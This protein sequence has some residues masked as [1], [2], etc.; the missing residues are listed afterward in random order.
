M[1]TLILAAILLIPSVAHSDDWSS[2]DTHRELGYL[3]LHITDLAQT[4]YAA[5]HPELQ[6]ET[7]PLLGKHP[8]V[9]Q[10]D[11]YMLLTGIVHTGIS[12]LLPSEYRKAFQYITIGLEVGTIHNNYSTG[13]KVKF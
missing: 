3:A 2:A 8:N 10:I 7:N 9:R 13:L 5:K 12:Y 6:Y 1:K 4:R 11:S